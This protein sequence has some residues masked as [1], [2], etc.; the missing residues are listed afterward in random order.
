MSGGSRRDRA[1][2]SVTSFDD[3]LRQA[4]VRVQRHLVKSRLYGGDGKGDYCRE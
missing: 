2:G 4:G 1:G 3:R